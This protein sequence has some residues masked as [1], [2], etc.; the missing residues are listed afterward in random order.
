MIACLGGS[1]CKYP[2]CV[3]PFTHGPRWE[4]SG[5]VGDGMCESAHTHC[6]SSSEMEDRDEKEDVRDVERK[7]RAC[8]RMV[9]PGEE[10][11]ENQREVGAGVE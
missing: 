5:S 3:S 11:G 7:C 10:A 6:T 9:A 4:L 2:L 8:C 1:A